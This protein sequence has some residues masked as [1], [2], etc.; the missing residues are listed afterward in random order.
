MRLLDAFE[1]SGCI[2]SSGLIYE[3]ATSFSLVQQEQ[4][5]F[6]IRDLLTVIEFNFINLNYQ[7]SLHIS[8]ITTAPVFHSSI[9]T[10]LLL[11]ISENSNS[12]KNL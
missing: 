2:A 8:T 6:S 1:L 4:Y 5:G 12:N 10:T 9:T 7:M 11:P 3:V